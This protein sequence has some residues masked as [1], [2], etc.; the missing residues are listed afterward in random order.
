[1]KPPHLLF[2]DA[3]LV[4]GGRRVLGPLSWEVSGGER[5][6]V[7]GPNGA[8]KTSLMRLAGATRLPSRGSVHVLGER[9]GQT[10]LQDLRRRIGYTSGELLRRFD[11]SRSVLEVVTTAAQ[12]SMRWGPE[13]CPAEVI[14]RA[15]LL[16]DRVGCRDREDQPLATLSEGER[17]RVLLARAMFAEPELLLL[18]EPAAGLDLR[19]REEVVNVIDGALVNSESAIVLVTHH[20]EEIPSEFTHA[21]LLKGGRPT[22]AGPLDQILTSEKLSNCFGFP[23]DLK[24]WA[25]RYAAAVRQG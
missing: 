21:L 12:A 9:I 10:H 16:L 17:Q 15:R 19:G 8:G 22:A 18:D 13:G 3:C 14:H 23:L 24:R 11:Q 6:V 20:L 1:M 25:G 2:R 5:W 7:L 4:E